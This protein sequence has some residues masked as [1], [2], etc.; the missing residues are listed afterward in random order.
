[1]LESNKEDPIWRSLFLAWREF[2]QGKRP[3]LEV[4]CFQYNL[5]TN[6]LGLTND[7]IND[8]YCHGGY[9]K[10]VVA[11]KKRRDLAV[12][13]IRDRVV[14]RLIYDELTR[15]YDKTFDFD[16][17][18]CRVDKGLHRCLSRTQ[19]LT[20]KY[21]EH[22]I[23]RMDIAKFFDNVDH[24]VLKNYLR[25]RVMDQRTLRICDEIIDSYSCSLNEKFAN[26]RRG[27]PIGNL[28]SQVFAN[29]YLNEFDRFV[30]RALKPLAY[31]RY[32]DD[33][34]IFAR[35]RHQANK[36]RE[37]AANFLKSELKLTVNPRND[38]IFRA[39]Q[40]IRFLGHII[41]EKSVVVDSRTTQAVLAK[42]NLRNLASYKSLHL[43][44]W[45]KRQ[46]DFL[47]ADIVDDLP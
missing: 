12:A 27:I 18:S 5:F 2:P 20:K 15:I 29:I 30:R 45:P 16:V 4:D 26:A 39:N 34:L 9:R 40:Q 3:I 43:A 23:W 11:E 14:H 17:W 6:L 41:T 25:R 35:T 36:F 46:L 28:T 38:A 31:I 47:A 44:K 37:I 22:F 24:K 13:E 1:M 19:H 8:N 21:K 32:G 42:V 10:V 33:T 7:I